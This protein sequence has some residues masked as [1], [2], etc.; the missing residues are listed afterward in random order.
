MKKTIKDLD[1]YEKRVLLRADFNVPMTD[2]KITSDLRIT[3][4]LS[5]INY[6]LK[7]R[8]KLIICS[9][10]GRPKGI[11]PK[12]S[13]KPVADRLQEL[14]PH[15]PIKFS[16]QIVGD[17][18][19][20]ESK[21]LKSGEILVLE[22]LRFYSQEEENDE[23]FAKQLSQ[24]ADV[25][26]FDAFGTSHRKHAS[27]YGVAKFLPSAMGFL[28]E[29]ELTAFSK[30]LNK[31][32]RPLVAIM[33]GAKIGDKIDMTENLLNK[34]NVML[35][36]GGMCFTFLKA[37]KGN[38]GNSLVDDDKV[39][40]CH[41]V[42]KDAIKKK[43]EIVL[44]VDFVCA[45]SLNDS[46]TKI[47]TLGNIPNDYMGLDI[48]PKTVELFGKYIEK[49][50]TLVWNGPMGVYENPLFANGTRELGI[51]VGQNKHCFS[52]AGGGDLVS[53]LE[54]FNLSHNF[55]HIS[56]GGGASMQL[57]EGKTLPAV[58]VLSNK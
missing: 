15:T 40:F 31:P 53:A 56:T 45:K 43:V 10:L 47:F 12:F 7:K 18:V 9:H 20:K 25:F 58:E 41:N 4:E 29:K 32:K 36:G 23:E 17:E 48:G 37:L 28:M 38:V 26:V 8:A 44:P 27:T 49:A 3:E 39:E 52:I 5:T 46:S 13:L 22:N 14:L 54:Q 19:V 33:G 11:D 35:I 51:K 21:E 42:V 30:A 55:K 57:L 1:V 16:S 2:K 50:R 24:L 6:L 34:V